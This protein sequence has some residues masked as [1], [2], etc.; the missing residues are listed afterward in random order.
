M[1]LT[2]ILVSP[3]TVRCCVVH[4]INCRVPQPAVGTASTRCPSRSLGYTTNQMLEIAV[5]T[6]AMRASCI[7]ETTRASMWRF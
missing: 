6:S 1:V 2:L 3:C 4:G 7:A 5:K